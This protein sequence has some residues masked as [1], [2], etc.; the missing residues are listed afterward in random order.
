MSMVMR[1]NYDTFLLTTKIRSNW[2]LNRSSPNLSKSFRSVRTCFLLVCSSWTAILQSMSSEISKHVKNDI[3]E[4]LTANYSTTGRVESLLSC[5]TIMNTFRQYFKYR[6]RWTLCGIRKV[7]FLGT[8]EDW[9]LLRRKTA[10][11]Q[12]LT[13]AND[14]FHTYIDSV[15]PVLDQLISTYQNK[16]DNEFWDQIFNVEHEGSGSG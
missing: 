13:T 2:L 7:H 1:K 10:K 14:D 9:L 12:R 8:L 3:V 16:V 5:A 4:L 15:L 11:L 6:L